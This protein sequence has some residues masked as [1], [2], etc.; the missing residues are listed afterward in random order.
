MAPLERPRLGNRIMSGL[1]QGGLQV[2][3]WVAHLRL[4]FGITIFRQNSRMLS[5][6]MRYSGFS[7][8]GEISTTEEKAVSVLTY[9]QRDFMSEIKTGAAKT[10]IYWNGNVILTKFLSLSAPKVVILLTC[11]FHFSV[12]TQHTQKRELQLKLFSFKDINLKIP[13]AILQ[14]FFSRR[15]YKETSGLADQPHKWPVKWQGILWGFTMVTCDTRDAIA[16]W[17]M[18]LTYWS[19]KKMAV[20]LQTTFY[21]HFCMK[22]CEFCINFIKICLQGSDWQNINQHWSKIWISAFRQ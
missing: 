18:T 22:Y 11:Y 4:C 17:M 14:P 12:F 16:I 15:L 6:K 7:T 19:F 1:L 9:S 21:M 3:Y 5:D 10:D 8:I 20:N 13:S 2:G